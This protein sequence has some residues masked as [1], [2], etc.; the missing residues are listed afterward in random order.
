MIRHRLVWKAFLLYTDAG[1]ASGTCNINALADAKSRLDWNV[2]GYSA[3]VHARQ[4][5]ETPEHG[6]AYT[7]PH[8][9]TIHPH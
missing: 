2:I 5:Q 7:T 9:G 6:L 1:I 3:V 4:T 8:T